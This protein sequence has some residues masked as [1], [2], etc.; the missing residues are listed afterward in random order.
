MSRSHSRND[1]R[2]LE[3]REKLIF[4][5]EI[6]SSIGCGVCGIKIPTVLT[7]HHKDKSQKVGDISGMIRN[8]SS[9][10]K[11]KAEIAK[12]EVLCMNC[13][14]IEEYMETNFV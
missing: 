14:A 5:S 13:H 3:R 8:N 1:R 12:C 7:F 4:V 2:K 11:I 9:I 10:D 6:K